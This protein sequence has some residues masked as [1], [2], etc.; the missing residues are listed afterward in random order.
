[1]KLL[2]AT[3]A[4]SVLKAAQAQATTAS[5]D[6]SY[7]YSYSFSDAPAAT[8]IGGGTTDCPLITDADTCNADAACYGWLAG[9]IDTPT[10]AGCT[11]NTEQADCTGDCDWYAGFCADLAGDDGGTGGGTGGGD[12]TE[13]IGTYEE[14]TDMICTDFDLIEACAD[15]EGTGMDCISAAMA[16][17]AISQRI[18]KLCDDPCATGVYN[19]PE[20]S[21][22][23]VCADAIVEAVLSCVEFFDANDYIEVVFSASMDFEG[24]V[25][26]SDPEEKSFMLSVLAEAIATSSGSD[27]VIIIS[28]D[29]T[30]MMMDSGRRLDASAVV[31]EAKV[32]VAVPEG[33]TSAEVANAA[34]ATATT[35]LN[36]VVTGGTFAD[37][38]NTAT[39]S[40]V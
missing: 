27:S 2:L 8:P 7:S 16:N 4:F 10:S 37:Q 24:V 31:F 21:M 6:P 39:Q 22:C 23:D 1:M 19:T 35:E 13:W 28:I 29:G 36:N 15:F 33:Q 26:P 34:A 18:G 30:L 38:M 20:F 12:V 40:V 3:L 14:A 32:V 9:C 11:S 17:E 5:A 25:V